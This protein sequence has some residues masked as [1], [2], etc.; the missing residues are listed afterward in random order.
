MTGNRHFKITVSFASTVGADLFD[1]LVSNNERVELDSIFRNIQSR[2]TSE[3]MD[4][5]RWNSKVIF[6]VMMQKFGTVVT[7][8][9][10]F[11]HVLKYG[12]SLQECL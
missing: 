11:L 5:K 4:E 6:M 8:L 10:R 2:K 9:Q 3:K 12:S 7:F 1:L